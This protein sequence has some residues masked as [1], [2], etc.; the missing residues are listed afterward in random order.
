AAPVQLT[1]T[2]SIQPTV[3]YADKTQLVQV[4]SVTGLTP[5]S[6]S[7]V[8]TGQTLTIFADPSALTIMYNSTPSQAPSQITTAISSAANST[9]P[10]AMNQTMT[11]STAMP[12]GQ[13]APSSGLSTAA[14]AAIGIIIIIVIAA[15]A[16]LFSRQ[17][18]KPSV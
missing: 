1:L 5:T 9:T 16:I 7:W 11:N 17:G 4:A 14:L 3:I 13:S 18:K 8:Y 12:A 2:S 15:G 10:V 6:N